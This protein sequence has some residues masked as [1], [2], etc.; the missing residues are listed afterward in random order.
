MSIWFAIH[1]SRC[2]DPVRAL[3]TQ[4]ALSVTSQCVWHERDTLLMDAT[5]SLQL[6]A[7]LRNLRRHLRVAL[8]DHLTGNVSDLR[9]SVSISA[10]GA[11]LLAQS[12]DRVDPASDRLRQTW[13]YALS[14]RQLIRQTDPMPVGWLTVCRPYLKWLQGVGCTSLGALRRLPRAQLQA[15]TQTGVL[16]MLDQIEARAI[17]PYRR[18]ELPEHFMVRQ[19]LDEPVH[20]VERIQVALHPLLRRMSQWLS[21]RHQAVRVWEVRLFHASQRRPAAPAR[22]RLALVE[23]DWR[24]DRLVYLMEIK[25]Q[26]WQLPAPVTDLMILTLV[27]QPRELRH[28]TLFADAHTQQQDLRYMLD[29]LRTRLGDA[30]IRTPN[31]QSD[32]RPERANQWHALSSGEATRSAHQDQPVAGLVSL[33]HS[34]AW[35]L[36]APE[37]LDV[38]DDRPWLKGALDLMHGPYRMETGWWDHQPVQRDYFVARDTYQRHYWIY[39]EHNPQGWTWYLH[40]LFG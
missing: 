4:L 35:L 1:V 11:W 10:M 2:P 34:P 31:P 3:L 33:Q 12:D 30:A 40:G 36:P 16:L 28:P 6:F 19:H 13:R 18:C 24:F 39:R 29:T 9:A 5:A 32:Y 8:A 26:A 20:Q 38:R 27:T 37:R 14:A 22:L 21:E 7:G 25:L 23:P 15:R 17:W